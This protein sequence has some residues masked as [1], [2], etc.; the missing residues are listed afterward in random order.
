MHKVYCFASLFLLCCAALAVTAQTKPPAF[1]TAVAEAMTAIVN[2]RFD[3]AIEKLEQVLAAT[4]GDTEALSLL[5]TA[6]AYKETDT[7]KAKQH[8]LDAIGKGGGASFIVSH[9]H[10]VSLMS[11]G[12]PNDYCRGWLHLRKGQVFFV[13]DNGAHSFTMPA[14]DIKEFKQNRMP[15]LFHIEPRNEKQY[16]EKNYNFAPRSRD[17]RETLLIVIMF[18]KLATAK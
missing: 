15:K 16:A 13:A 9:S 7:M 18:Q 11:M 5:A 8:F 2:T 14:A 6:R 10:E 17:D 4:P 3:Y 1:S 12:D